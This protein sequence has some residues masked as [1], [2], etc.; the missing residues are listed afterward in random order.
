MGHVATDKPPPWATGEW[1][2]PNLGDACLVPLG[3]RNAVGM[4]S[5]PG[6]KWNT[7]PLRKRVPGAMGG[8]R[9]VL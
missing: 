5:Q 7:L 3:V 9:N 8:V 2:A 6:L 4:T 1:Y